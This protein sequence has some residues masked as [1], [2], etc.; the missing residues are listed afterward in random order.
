MARR[1]SAVEPS[2]IPQFILERCAVREDMQRIYTS[3]ASLLFSTLPVEIRGSRHGR[4]AS[5]APWSLMKV[6]ESGG[7]VS[8]RAWSN[9]LCVSF[10]VVYTLVCS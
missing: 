2:G 1:P 9:V 4:Y 6:I 10:V 8:Q 3:H 5:F 7:R